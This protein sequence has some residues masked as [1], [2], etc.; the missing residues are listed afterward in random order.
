MKLTKFAFAMAIALTGCNSSTEHL[1]SLNP[2]NF[3][4]DI[5]VGDDFYGH[6]NHI[7]QQTHPLSDEY[8]RYGNFNV[9]ADTAEVRVRDLVLG[10]DAT[11]PEPG[12]VAHKVSTI[13]EQGM[14]SVRRNAEGAQPILA[15]LRKIEETPHDGMEELFYWMQANYSNP[16]VSAGPMEDLSNSNAYAMYIE[17]GAMTLGDRDYYLDDSERNVTVREAYK[18]LVNTQMQNAGYTPEEA[19]RITANV[20]KI[21][22][23]MAE[24]AWTREE[25]RRIELMNN[26]RSMA[27]LQQMY[28]AVNW[29]RFF[30][31]TMEI[32]D[33]DT[34]IVTQ[35]EPIQ[36]GVELL[37]SLSDREIKDF[38]LWLYVRQ[39]APYLSDNFADASFEFSKVMRGVKEQRPRWK[40][41]LG[42]TESLLGEAIGELY[43]EK[44]FPESSKEYMVGLVENLRTALGEHIDNL[45]WMSDSTKANARE[46]L[47]AFTVKIGYPDKW[48]DY[49]SMTIDPA[50]S[51]YENTHNASMW[52]QK[53]QL[54]KWGKPVDKTEWG[55]TPQTVNAYYNPMANE[56][57]FPAAILQA[58]FF[59]PEASDA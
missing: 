27:E 25:N 31:A 14:D 42:T 2:D 39:A 4:K 58:P 19:A 30:P 48:K 52:H 10:L 9:L 3:D 36:R 35:I 34:V 28:P 49:S 46:K 57:V 1:K 32:N 7:W 50:L 5:P 59:D 22:T 29:E 51:Y 53:E 11:N 13:Y 17:P 20:M 45:T 15:D 23:A 16:F 21:E 18:T 41:A 6:V 47:A 38:Y 40:R 12:S 44:Y 26:P 55:M 43:V 33:V 56:I 54:A 37:G 8:A 24:K